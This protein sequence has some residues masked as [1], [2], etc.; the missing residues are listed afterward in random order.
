MEAAE[1]NVIV[2]PPA[3]ETAT[4]ASNIPDIQPDE[5]PESKEGVS[6]L[7]AGIEAPL[8]T[9]DQAD[10]PIERKPSQ[11]DAETETTVMDT[12]A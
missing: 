8:A 7:P 3:V 1:A 11:D 2:A 4:I 6:S 12:A 5:R 9:V 10:G